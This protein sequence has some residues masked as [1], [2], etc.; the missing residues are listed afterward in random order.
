V[1]EHDVMVGPHLSD[2]EEGDGVRQVGRPERGEA[3]QQVPGVLR[4]AD[5]QDEQGDGDGED[6]IAE[7]DEPRRIAFGAEP[8]ARSLP[9]RRTRRW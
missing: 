9:S 7:E 4:R 8:S 2:E 5:L 6:R 3:L 1:V